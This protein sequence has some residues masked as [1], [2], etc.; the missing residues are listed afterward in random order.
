MESSE[1]TNK[2][3]LDWQYLQS[4][5]EPVNNSQQHLLD[6]ELQFWDFVY[7]LICIADVNGTIKYVNR[8]WLEITGL[9]EIEANSS[10]LFDIV[11][12]EERDNFYYPN[13][14]F[15]YYG[16]EFIPWKDYILGLDVFSAWPKQLIWESY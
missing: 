12:F 5:L 14:N 9:N 11:H 13:I 2:S 8:R 10:K 3:N 15:N 1:Y 4:K 6:C 7:H 16:E